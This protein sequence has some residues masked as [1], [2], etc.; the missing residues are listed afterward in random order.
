MIMAEAKYNIYDYVIAGL[1]RNAA[2]Y[3]R[4]LVSAADLDT[5]G[6]MLEKRVKVE[7]PH[8]QSIHT[9]YIEIT[10]YHSDREGVILLTHSRD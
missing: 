10:P 9:R 8:I 1:N 6:Q 3:F 2:S 4:S 7:F 5:A